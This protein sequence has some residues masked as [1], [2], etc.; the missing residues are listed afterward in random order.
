MD[1][2]DKRMRKRCN[3]NDARQEGPIVKK[4]LLTPSYSISCPSA[5][6]FLIEIS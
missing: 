3:E 2:K 1:N 4:T 6:P 5:L